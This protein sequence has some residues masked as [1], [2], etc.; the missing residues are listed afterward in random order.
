MCC[1]L[2][3]SSR[4]VCQTAFF[5]TVLIFVCAAFSPVHPPRIT[6]PDLTSIL[7]PSIATPATRI[8]KLSAKKGS[9]NNK[10]DEDV[11]AL[12]HSHHLLD[13]TPDNLILKGGKHKLRGVACLGRPG[14]ALCV[15]PSKSVTKF[16]AS[17]ESA[18]PQ[19]RFKTKVLED[20]APA[21]C[22]QFDG[23][24]QVDLGGFRTVLASIGE[25]SEFFALTGIDPEI[26]VGGGNTGG[27]YSSNGGK[28]EIQNAGRRKNK[29]K[30]KQ[31]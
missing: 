30:R 1:R 4:L 23:F 8:T 15:G 11:V 9:S 24:E 5:M 28:G 19:K 14:V 25:E 21:T 29:R 2:L 27:D 6:R 3:A 10:G 26:A 7:C 31:K 20:V 13:H 18:M 12:L 16:K 17:L 22:S